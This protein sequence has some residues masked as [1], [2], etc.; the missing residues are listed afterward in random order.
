LVSHSEEVIDRQLHPG[1]PTVDG[2]HT[3]KK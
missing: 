3:V 2:F 1:N